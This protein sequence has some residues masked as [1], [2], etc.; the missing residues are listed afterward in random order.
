MFLKVL[1]LVPLFAFTAFGAVAQTAPQALSSDEREFLGKNPILYSFLEKEIWPSES[2]IRTALESSLP[3]IQEQNPCAEMEVRSFGPLGYG[4][5]DGNLA[6][7][8]AGGRIKMAWLVDVMIGGCGEENPYRFI[9]L[10]MPDDSYSSLV[11]SKGRTHAWPKLIKD[12]MMTVYGAVTLATHGQDCPVNAENF[13]IGPFAIKDDDSIGPYLF[14]VRYTGSWEEV[15]K[16]R[17]C[18]TMVSV[19]VTFRAD[20]QGGAY[21]NVSQD[22]V[23]TE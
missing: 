7:L 21:I 12:A 2:Q 9:L 3:A 16:I 13:E 4:M 11:G 23:T 10:Q 20:G 6:P 14:G 5:L 8:I 17:V 18:E 1:L 22:D 15:W 19:P